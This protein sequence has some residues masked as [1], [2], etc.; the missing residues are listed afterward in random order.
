[1]TVTAWV[2]TYRGTVFPWET[3]IV[4]HLTVA[5]YFERFADA[6]LAVLDGLGLGADYMAAARRGCVTEDCYVRYMH[7]L[8]VGDILH[9]E[10]AVIGVD[11]TG[12]RFGHR[13]VQLGHRGAVRDDG[14][15][16][17]PR[18]AG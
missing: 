2:D 16:D 4:E 6:T 5:Y 18:R 12:L 14:A 7:E 10:S 9:I 15:A 13:V 1:M 8:R 17:A 11:E 3:D